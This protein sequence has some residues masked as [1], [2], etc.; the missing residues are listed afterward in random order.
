[1]Y[2]YQKRRVYRNIYICEQKIKKAKEKKKKK[3]GLIKEGKE[4]IIAQG[5]AKCPRC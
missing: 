2:K 3:N 5:S 1:M 4:I